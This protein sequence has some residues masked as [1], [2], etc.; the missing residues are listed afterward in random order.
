MEK[1]KMEFEK[2]INIKH[3][4]T[5]S[6]EVIIRRPFAG[7]LN[8][9]KRIA[10]TQGKTETERQLILEEELLPYCIKKHP[11][12]ETPIKEA[13]KKIDFADHA[14]ICQELVQLMTDSTEEIVKKSEESL[15]PKSN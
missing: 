7:E 14:L 6:G 3:S 12:N 4:G 11:W 9:A 8:R 1:T 2:T 5:F 15:E 13:L 10:S